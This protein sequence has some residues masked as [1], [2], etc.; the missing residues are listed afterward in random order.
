MDTMNM[1][2]C[3]LRGPI[4]PTEDS[5]YLRGWI[6]VSKS[7]LE[8]KWKELIRPFEF[9][10]QMLNPNVKFE[11]PFQIVTQEEGVMIGK[12][13][14]K[15]A[16][17]QVESGYYPSFDA[18]LYVMDGIPTSEILHLTRSQSTHLAAELTSFMIN[19]LICIAEESIYIRYS[20]LFSRGDETPKYY[21]E[22]LIRKCIDNPTSVEHL[23]G[24]I[25]VFMFESTFPSTG[26]PLETSEIREIMN[27]LVKLDSASTEGMTTLSR[28]NFVAPSFYGN[29]NPALQA[30]WRDSG[31]NYTV[32]E[33]SLIYKNGEVFETI[34]SLIDGYSESLDVMRQWL[35]VFERM[36][37]I[38]KQDS[39]TKWAIGSFVYFIQ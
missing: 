22:D 33:T 27:S 9:N 25:P 23:N 12:E 13:G 36:D 30:I 37:D 4:D 21:D 15:L 14:R 38:S 32:S 39:D 16:A 18:H 17:A 31:Y 26:Y 2:S 5:D 3:Y 1:I 24:E 7:D 29:V 28:A 6:H 34:S 35:W 11:L 19:H 8:A 20:H 10:I